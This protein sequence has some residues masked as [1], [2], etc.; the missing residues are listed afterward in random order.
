MLLIACIYFCAANPKIAS[1]W[2][3]K[4]SQQRIA[5]LHITIS[6]HIGAFHE[7]FTNVR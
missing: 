2:V 7:F 1:M 3:L 4:D 6:L 5:Y